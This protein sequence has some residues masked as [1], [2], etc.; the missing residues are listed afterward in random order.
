ML[1]ACVGSFIE[2][3]EAAQI[4]FSVAKFGSAPSGLV[5]SGARCLCARIQTQRHLMA[6]RGRG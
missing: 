1:L 3:E 6:C 2:W 5:A 4:L